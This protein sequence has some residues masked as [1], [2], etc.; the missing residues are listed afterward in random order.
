MTTSRPN[1]SIMNGLACLQALALGKRAV[2]CRALAR[3][4]EL[5]PTVVNRVLGTLA[6]LGLAE[7]TP[8]RKYRPGPALH[9]LAVQS[10]RG[11]CL[12]PAVLP[13]MEAFLDDGYAVSVGV[14]W[15][16]SIC[17]LLHARPGQSLMAGI[18]THDLRP[19]TDSSVGIALLALRSKAEWPQGS[20]G[21]ILQAERR[22]YAEIVFPD[23]QISLGVALNESAG[24]AISK[25]FQNN[26][27]KRD[28]LARLQDATRIIA[29][30]IAVS[31]S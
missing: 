24:L 3:D 19:A 15:R 25:R 17:F 23:G 4:L 30:S 22:G 16:E 11:S 31:H 20:R 13:Q 14:L 21:A 29:E 7:R 10:M 12:L 1:N 2:G 6:L 28:A 18:G 9:V 8:N 5:D 27:D 26:Q